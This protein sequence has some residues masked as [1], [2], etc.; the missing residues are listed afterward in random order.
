MRTPAR[1]MH[2]LLRLTHASFQIS[3]DTGLENRYVIT[4]SINS[5]LARALILGEKIRPRQSVA[6]PTSAGHV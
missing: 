6:K 4:N 5:A 1:F 3:L 2:V